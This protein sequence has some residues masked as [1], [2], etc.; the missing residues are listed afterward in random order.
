VS[1][2]GD[3]LKG[4]PIRCCP[5]LHAPGLTRL[6]S[7]GSDKCTS[8]FGCFPPN[9]NPYKWEAFAPGKSLILVNKAVAYLT[10]SSL[11][12]YSRLDLTNCENEVDS[13]SGNKTSKLSIIVEQHALKHYHLHND[14]LWIMVL[15]TLVSPHQCKLGIEVSLCCVFIEFYKSKLV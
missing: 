15:R 10:G 6:E 13:Q 8:L 2:A 1:K 9:R 11:S 7:L 4:Q 5:Q 14:V 12:Y 3:W